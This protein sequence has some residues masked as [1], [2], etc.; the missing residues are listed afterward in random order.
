MKKFHL[1]VVA[2]LFTLYNCVSVQAETTYTFTSFDYT[3]GDYG[4]ESYD[5]D[6]NNIVG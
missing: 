6:G 2:G 5:V 3:G 1:N 4:T